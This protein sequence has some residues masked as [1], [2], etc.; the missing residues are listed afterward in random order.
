MRHT[1]YT[2]IGITRVPCM[3]CGKPSVHQWQICADGNQYRGVCLDCDIF[4]NGVVMKLMRVPGWR[5]K[6][7]AYEKRARAAIN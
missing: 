3:R 2:A 4:I 7:K 6:V 5:A 1:P